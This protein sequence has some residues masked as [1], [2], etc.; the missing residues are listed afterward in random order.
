MQSTE[1]VI[2]HNGFGMCRNRKAAFVDRKC[3]KHERHSLFHLDKVQRFFSIDCM[4]IFIS[5]PL[6]FAIKKALLIVG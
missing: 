5:G 4:K 6:S 1:A 2:L 3:V